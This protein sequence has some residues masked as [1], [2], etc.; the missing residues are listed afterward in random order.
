MHE[1]A[2]RGL[3]ASFH[4]HEQKQTKDYI[5][6]RR[7]S[8]LPAQLQW[9]TQLQNIA[10]RLRNN[11]DISTEQLKLDIFG[12]RIFVYS[13]K[14]DIYNLPEGA[15][16]LDFAYMVHS[17]IAK[18]AYSFRV[19]SKIHPFDKPLNNGDVVEVVTRKMSS[20][21]QDWLDLVKTTHAKQKL[22]MQLKQLGI[23]K[24]ISSAANII[25]QKTIRRKAK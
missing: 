5:K 21:K 19:N 6:K 3:A 10:T 8:T 23:I 4:Y 2:E 7:A 13:P 14:G 11:E 20:P 17:D 24:T 25:R 12:N 16:P 22:R 9:I 18:H 1:Y 15:L